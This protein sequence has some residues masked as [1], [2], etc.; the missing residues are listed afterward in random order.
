MSALRISDSAFEYLAVQVGELDKLKTVRHVWEKAYERHLFARMDNILPYIPSQAK[1][2][3]DVGSG[4]GG[5]D[6]LLYR[7]Y[8]KETHVT[9][10]DGSEFTPEVSKHNVP[11]NSKKVA[12]EFLRDNGV[13]ERHSH[14]MDCDSLKSQPF[15]LIV[16]FRAWCFH[17]KPS[18]YLEFVRRCCHANTK[19]ILDI[20]KT[21]FW[22]VEVAEHFDGM[23]ID[24]G[25]KHERWALTV[26]KSSLLLQADGP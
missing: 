10:L 26:K 6:I 20:R 8:D 19:V 13:N 1:T 24:D 14:F 2:V 15:D 5:I 23:I 16:S 25:E 17:I 4:L 12:I 3:L 9:L 18:M 22:R 11:F 21:P 7:W